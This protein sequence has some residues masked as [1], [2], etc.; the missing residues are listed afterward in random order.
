MRIAPL[1]F[2][3]LVMLE[4]DF[5]QQRWHARSVVYS[6][7]GIVATSQTLASA[8]GDRKSTRLNSSH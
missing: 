8:A 4:P 2:L 6:T 7:G 5:A 1:L 3:T